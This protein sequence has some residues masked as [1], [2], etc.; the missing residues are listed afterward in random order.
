V[1]SGGTELVASGGTV[2]NT[3]V[4]SGGTLTV[5]GLVN[6]A[7]VSS[8][9]TVLVGNGG[10]LAVLS[11]QSAQG[12]VVSI[13]GTEIVS[14]GGTASNTVV[15]GGTLTV[16]GLANGAVVSSGVLIPGFP[17]FNVVGSMNVMSGGTATNTVV[18]SGGYETVSSGGVL[19]GALISG[20][21]IEIMSGGSA[22]SGVITFSSG[23]T[24]QLDS[25]VS[26][27]GTISGFAL[28]DQLDL[29]DVAFGSGTTLSFSEAG[30]NLSG[31]LT[32]SDGTH[33]AHL[34]LLGQYVTAQFTKASDGHGGTLVGDPPIGGPASAVPGEGTTPEHHN[35]RDDV[36]STQAGSSDA[37]KAPAN[38]WP[39][40]DQSN[41]DPMG[42]MSELANR[43][44]LPSTHANDPIAKGDESAVVFAPRFSSDGP[45]EDVPRSNHDI[46]A[47]FS[48]LMAAAGPAGG[49][50]ILAKWA[51]DN[52]PGPNTA[53]FA[54]PLMPDV[55]TAALSPQAAAR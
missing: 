51:N 33:A 34:T 27:G 45:N 23:G 29:R 35:E 48:R 26:F 52:N 15:S 17:A 5:S 31:T 22:N 37:L 19:S 50:A 25:S 39:N 9:A 36:A 32:V 16:R 20:G 12:G 2:S 28:P 41:I 47:S 6:G 1:L 44:I 14:A 4:S 53:S 30:N 38:V 21:T 18:N 46:F 7:T 49:D 54:S 10:T 40:T 13:S 42:S 55:K 11:G 3:T 43:L 8:G 24:L